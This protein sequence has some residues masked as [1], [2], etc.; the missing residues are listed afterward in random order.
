VGEGRH[1][2]RGREQQDLGPHRRIVRRDDLFLAGEPREL[3]QQ[4][5]AE[6]PG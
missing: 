3:D 2:D 1:Q 6:R 4:P 5:A